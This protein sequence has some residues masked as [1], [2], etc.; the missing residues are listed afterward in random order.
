LYQ[1]THDLEAKA[2]RQGGRK[3]TFQSQSKMHKI[4]VPSDLVS[5]NFDMWMQQE[6]A[7][8]QVL[9]YTL[10]SEASES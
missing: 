1:G 4:D 5:N 6:E 7:R 8:I 2:A 3:R 9:P 10:A